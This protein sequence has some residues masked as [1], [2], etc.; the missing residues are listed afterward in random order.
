MT[1]VAVKS[2]CVRLCA[3][4]CDDEIF[5]E[6]C[7]KSQRKS[8]QHEMENKSSIN[9]FSQNYIKNIIRT[10]LSNFAKILQKYR[11]E[12]GGTALLPPFPCTSPSLLRR[13]FCVSGLFGHRSELF[14]YSRRKVNG[15]RYRSYFVPPIGGQCTR[16]NLP[17]SHSVVVLHSV[18]SVGFARLFFVRFLFSHPQSF[19]VRFVLCNILYF[20]LGVHFLSS[21]FRSNS[22]TPQMCLPGGKRTGK[23]RY[24]KFPPPGLPLVALPHGVVF[25]RPFLALGSAL[26]IG[27]VRMW[28]RKKRTQHRLGF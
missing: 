18:R 1:N 19:L 13:F 27:N 24:F 9:Y 16:P 22:K 6:L 10:T 25:A 28:R 21:P 26:G 4:C 3:K 20:I 17:Q 15:A 11:S 5:I 14:A 8:D 23:K 2:L 12:H 7:K